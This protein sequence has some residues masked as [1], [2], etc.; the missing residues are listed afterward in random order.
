MVN[1][2]PPGFLYFLHLHHI[3]ILNLG[4]KQGNMSSIN[5]GAAAAII[6]PSLRTYADSK[7]AVCR[8]GKAV[9]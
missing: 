5:S 6:N 9:V 2:S 1:L 4:L 3:H 7:V 8:E